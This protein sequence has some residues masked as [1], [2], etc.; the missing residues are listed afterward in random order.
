MSWKKLEAA[1][2]EKGRK[3]YLDLD[4]D[5]TLLIIEL[6]VVVGIHLQVMEGEFLLDSFLECLA[7]FESKRVG[8]GDHRD[9]VD[10]VGQ[11]LEDDNI[12]RLE[13]KISKHSQRF[14]G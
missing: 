10:D 6:L 9:D 7:L 4:V 5:C 14:P 13:T 2:G 11:F 12:D 1:H 8:L 3:Q